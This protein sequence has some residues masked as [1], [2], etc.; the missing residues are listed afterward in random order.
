MKK[1]MGWLWLFYFCL[2]LPVIA[3]TSFTQASKQLQ[4]EYQLAIKNQQ[5]QRKQLAKEKKAML[6]QLAKRRQTVAAL[7][8][9]IK[10]LEAEFESLQHQEQELASRQED[11]I[12]EMN[13][14]AGTVRTSVKDLLSLIDT[15]LISGLHP[16][17]AVGLRQYLAAD[18][19]PSMVDV[20][21]IVATYFDEIYG[22][23][24]IIKQHGPFVGLQGK[25]TQ[26][27]IVCLGA[28]T[29][30]YHRDD[31]GEIGFAVY[32]KENDAMLAVSKAS[33]LVKRCLSKYLT[34]QSNEVYLDFSGGSTVRQLALQPTAWE[35]LCSGGPLV[36][37]ILLLGLVALV[38]SLERF[39]FLRR[40]KSNTDKVMSEV[41]QL[42]AEDKWQES[43]ELLSNRRGP[44]YNVLAAGLRFRRASWEILENVLEEA[45]MK[46][47]PS[48]ERYLPTLQV[49]AAVAPLLGLLGTVT[50]MINTFQV[51]T[52]FGTGDPKMMSGGISEALITTELGLIMAIPIILLHS[53]FSRKVESII[54]DMEEKAV[55]LTVALVNW[56]S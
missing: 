39:F 19:F 3:A 13:Q 25:M 21:K 5:E 53:Y 27:E 46:E 29:A 47:L 31:N 44:V 14:L 18:R 51:I 11:V 12:Q 42:L 52:I 49:L 50:G 20:K 33:W 40:V 15:S 36:W 8:K 2:P 4:N 35:R 26:G 45:I 23:S 30:F 6:G 9:N 10:E 28:L 38:L 43:E 24:Q 48:L 7:E 54:G 37:P 17:R 16:R 1:F 32:G 22:S 41:I 56:E 55:G 34:G